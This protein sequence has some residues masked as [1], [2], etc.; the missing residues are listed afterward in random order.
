[1]LL[2]GNTTDTD[3]HVRQVWLRGGVTGLDGK[4][5]IAAEGEY[6]SRANLYSRDREIA[7]T[8]DLSNNPGGLQQGGVN[9]NSPT[10]GGR[11]SVGA[12]ATA[13]GYTTTGQLVLSD[14]T[15]VG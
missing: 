2:Y 10:Y 12:G 11:I 13:I 1:M 14:L 5:S 7:T 8:A 4:V 15:S 6:Y 3:A 9:S